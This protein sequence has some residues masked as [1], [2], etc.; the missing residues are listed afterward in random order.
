MKRVLIIAAVVGLALALAKKRPEASTWQGMSEEQARERLAE[1]LP[2]QMPD[3]ARE[4]ATDKIVDKMRDKGVI[5]DLTD[6]AA[7][8]GSDAAADEP[9]TTS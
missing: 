5:I 7:A 4:A 8:D 3:A 1:R 2:S 9:S 6:E